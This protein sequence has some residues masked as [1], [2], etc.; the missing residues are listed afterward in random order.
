MLVRPKKHNVEKYKNLLSHIKMRKEIL[1]IGDIEIVKKNYHHNSAIF[2]KDADIKQVLVSNK[3]SFSEE[4]YKFII[5]YFYNNKKFKLLHVM[6][7]K[8]KAYVKSMMGKL[9]GCIF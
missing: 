2:L 5:G 6:L 4:N 9:N 7:H 1:K 8:K 3:I